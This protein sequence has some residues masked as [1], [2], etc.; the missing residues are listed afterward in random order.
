MLNQSIANQGLFKML[1]DKES[2]NITHENFW[3][4]IQNVADMVAEQKEKNGENL[5]MSFYSVLLEM[6]KKY[7]SMEKNKIYN[8]NDYQ[9]FKNN[10]VQIFIRAS[11]PMEFM[12]EIGMSPDKIFL[13]AVSDKINFGNRKEQTIA[14][15]KIAGNSMQL[16]EFTNDLQDFTLNIFRKY[17]DLKKGE[18]KEELKQ[19]VDTLLEAYYKTLKKP[20]T[21]ELRK[22]EYV[23]ELENEHIK[24]VLED[25][26]LN[27]EFYLDPN[28]AKE[29]FTQY[30]ELYKKI[31]YNTEF[32]KMLIK[33][34]PEDKQK[35]F[36]DGEQIFSDDIKRAILGK[37]LPKVEDIK[38]EK[39]K[40]I[41][42]IAKFYI[43]YDTYHDLII[44][45][46]TDIAE[47]FWEM[48]YGQKKTI[49]NNTN[50]NGLYSEIL[51]SVPEWSGEVNL[52]SIN[53]ITNKITGEM[54]NVNNQNR[55]IEGD[56]DK[57]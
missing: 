10:M 32:F 3:K 57:C 2:E 55:S 54:L 38:S 36:K 34:L 46:N 43:I 8:E 16:G 28:K 6:T 49:D 14:L 39:L 47:E 44:K 35:E 48:F 29:I 52:D 20:T 50:T 40:E 31:E 56:I 9:E 1:A 7:V 17:E 53:K 33:D 23:Y 37:G 24:N 19:Y 51:E 25:V 5:Y 13:K 12:N 4:K 45:G 42:E 21:V 18:N 27:P 26:V 41:G 11:V 22:S 15:L 30:P